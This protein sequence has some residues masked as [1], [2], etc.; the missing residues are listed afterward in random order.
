MRHRG[1]EGT[2]AS[3][4]S[5][6]GTA[7]PRRRILLFICHPG[8]EVRRGAAGLARLCALC[9]SVAHCLFFSSYLASWRSP[10]SRR[11]VTAVAGGFAIGSASDC[12]TASDAGCV[13][14]EW[15]SRR[16][17]ESHRFQP[18]GVGQIFSA[19]KRVTPAD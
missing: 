8:G 1:T 10:F 17:G 18:P 11:G 13:T 7:N 3:F 4:R 16:P 19:E 6:R 12:E 2:E 9:V 14:A 5:L 15:R